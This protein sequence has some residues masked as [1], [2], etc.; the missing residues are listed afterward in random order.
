MIHISRSPTPPPCKN[1]QTKHNTPHLPKDLL[2][3]MLR[4]KA[5]QGLESLVFGDKMR[6]IRIRLTDVNSDDQVSPDASELADEVDPDG[7]TVR[8]RTLLH[9]A[10]SLSDHLLVLESIR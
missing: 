3:D 1:K 6:K 5:M 4:E 7:R 10:V 2:K 9:L 8:G